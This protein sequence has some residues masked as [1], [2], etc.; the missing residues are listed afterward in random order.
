MVLK[1]KDD[2][3]KKAYK[4]ATKGAELLQSLREMMLTLLKNVYRM[5]IG[6]YLLTINY[7]YHFNHNLT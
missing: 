5:I 1:M 2:P 3:Y 7:Y 6:R 4:I